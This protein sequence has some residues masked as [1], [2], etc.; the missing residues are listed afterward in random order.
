[1]QTDFREWIKGQTVEKVA[2][3]LN[4]EANTVYSWS[5]RNRIPY[6]LWPEVVLAF[7]EIGLNDLLDME[8]A[9]RKARGE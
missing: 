4:V 8:D 9:A 2:E 6:K 7:S 3:K 5:H 1:M